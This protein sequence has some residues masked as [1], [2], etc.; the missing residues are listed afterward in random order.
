MA[1]CLFHMNIGISTEETPYTHEASGKQF[2]YIEI[3]QS[4]VTYATAMY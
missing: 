1:M 3:M 4:I 2:N